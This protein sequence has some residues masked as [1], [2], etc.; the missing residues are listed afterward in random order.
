[1][2]E[3]ALITLATFLTASIALYLTPGASIQF[4]SATGAL[5]GLFA[6]F[7]RRAGRTLNRIC[8][9]VFCGLAA[10]LALN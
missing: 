5:A 2:P 1:M 9:F 6:E 4:I 8:A 7:L 10:R 3:F